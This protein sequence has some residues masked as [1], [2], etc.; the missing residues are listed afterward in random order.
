MRII[1]IS[2]S[3]GELFIHE[4]VEFDQDS[5]DFIDDTPLNLPLSEALATIEVGGHGKRLS[6]LVVELT[7]YSWVDKQYLDAVIK[8]I[9]ENYPEAD[10]SWKETFEYLDGMK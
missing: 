10:I 8:F 5:P 4:L 6:K 3:E 9:R 7:G 2:V 1:D